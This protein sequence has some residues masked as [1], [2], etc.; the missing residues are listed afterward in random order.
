MFRVEAWRGTAQCAP[1]VAKIGPHRDVGEEIGTANNFVFDHVPFPN[2]PPFIH[3]RCVTGSRKSVLVSRLVD[4]AHRLDTHFSSLQ[5]SE[6][7]RVMELLFEGAFRFWREK[8]PPVAVQ[9][10]D[11][12]F[13]IGIIPEVAALTPA[14]IAAAKDDAGI[15]APAALIALLESQ[16]PQCIRECLG[17]GDLQVRN[18]FVRHH[19]LNIRDVIDVVAIDFAKSGVATSAARDLTTLEVSIALDELDGLTRP[20][21]SDL[22]QLYRTV[23]GSSGCRFWRWMVGPIK[24]RGTRA[25]AVRAIRQQAAREGIP[26]QEYLFSL[27]AHLLRYSRFN[28]QPIEMRALAYRAAALLARQAQFREH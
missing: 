28:P 4:H 7:A 12:Y 27:I 15:L 13:Q 1:F 9:L 26:R 23:L 19:P 2:H 20:T 18:I 21:W 17:H 8:K 5:P 3:D 6:T 24:R 22:L 10:F 16:S 14:W 25:V 11:R